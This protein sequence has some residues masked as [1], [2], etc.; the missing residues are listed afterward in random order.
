LSRRRFH[1]SV[2]AYAALVGTMGIMFFTGL[3]PDIGKWYSSSP[4]HRAQVDA[5]LRGSLALSACPSALRHDLAWS[6]AGVHQVW[7]LGVPLCRLPFDALA[8]ICGSQHFPDRISFGIALGLVAWCVLATFWRSLVPFNLGPSGNAA[9]PELG[10]RVR[11][12]NGSASRAMAV[13]IWMGVVL[14]VLLFPPFVGLL[15]SRF[16]VYEEVIAYEYLAGVFL[17]CQM[18]VLARTPTASRYYL[19]CLCSGVGALV[20][21]TMLCYSAGTVA[22]GA[23]ALC[24]GAA[25]KGIH[26]VGGPTLAGFWPR[27]ARWFVLGGSMVGLGSLPVLSSNAVRFGSPFEFGHKLNLQ[28]L[29]SS[30]YSTRFEAPYEKEPLASAAVELFGMMFCTREL[31]GNRF[32]QPAVFPGQSATVRWREVYL[33]TYSPEYAALLVMALV[34]AGH[35]LWPLVHGQR[36]CPAWRDMGEVCWPRQ[37][38]PVLCLWGLASA[39]GLVFL[40]LRIPCIASRYLLDF[41]PAFVAILAAGWLDA[42]RQLSV[43]RHGHLLIL[44]SLAVLVT[45]GC[46]RVAGT[47]CSYGGPVARSSQELEEGHEAMGGST[48]PTLPEKYDLGDNLDRFGIPFNGVGWAGQTGEMMPVGIWFVSDPEYIELAVGGAGAP[49]SEA[50]VGIIRAKIGLEALVRESLRRT[51]S[52]WNIRFHGPL[53]KRYQHGLQPLFVAILPPQEMAEGQT[54]VRVLQLRWR[55]PKEGNLQNGAFSAGQFLPPRQRERWKA[56]AVPSSE[57]I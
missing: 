9:S 47:R 19:L 57:E 8:R 26:P 55:D 2:L 10:T 36:P 56:P 15:K 44:G 25:E 21:P 33:T 23:L 5:L 42:C 34:L 50:E 16:E 53:R 3:I 27:L 24:L 38:V 20:R 48:V 32:H 12:E 1:N 28:T 40:Y 43:R 35:S 37:Q 17:L 22:A 7:G 31:S 4:Y 54:S 6:E 52:G 13:C 41:M 11:P 49:L 14:L 30:V 29:Y 18:V 45:W 51:S 46:W 39:A